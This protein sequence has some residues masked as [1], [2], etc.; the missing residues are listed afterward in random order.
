MVSRK[1][2]VYENSDPAVAKASVLQETTE[3]FPSNPSIAMKMKSMASR[4]NETTKS[5][6]LSNICRHVR[7]TKL[8]LTRRVK[9]TYANVLVAYR[10]TE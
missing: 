1:I 3:T 9:G 10:T 8:E 4:D 6:E 5:R 2:D 7:P